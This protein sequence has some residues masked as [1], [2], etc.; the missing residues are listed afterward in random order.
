MS[1]K[2]RSETAKAEQRLLED[3][4]RGVVVEVGETGDGQWLRLPPASGAEYFWSFWFYPNGECHIYANL[5][6]SRHDNASKDYVLWYHPF[7]PDE[8]KQSAT[9]L[10]DAFEREMRSVLHSATRIT[11][12]RGPLNW[13]IDLDREDGQSGWKRVHRFFALRQGW[14]TPHHDRES[15]TYSAPA[16]T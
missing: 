6:L 5:N 7:E 14:E 16:F 11:H 9:Q 2:I 8:F 10:R 4:L 15:A 1:A 13:T 3:E 12:R